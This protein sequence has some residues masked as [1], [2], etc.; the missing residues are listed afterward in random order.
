[1]MSRKKNSNLPI[2]HYFFLQHLYQEKE[3]VNDADFQKKKK[4][5]MKDEKG[6]N[7]K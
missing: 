6:K 5:L 2:F 3:V 7:L 1:M 4:T